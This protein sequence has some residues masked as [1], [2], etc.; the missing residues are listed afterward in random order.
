M[1]G[2]IIQGQ[3][4]SAPGEAGAIQGVQIPH[5]QSVAGSPLLITA[6]VAVTKP[7]KPVC[8]KYQAAT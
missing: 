4:R 8:G 6:L 1:V 5:G 7:M 2:G 3:A